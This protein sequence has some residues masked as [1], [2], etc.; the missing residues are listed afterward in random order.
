MSPLINFEV[1][2][3]DSRTPQRKELLQHHAGVLPLGHAPGHHHYC[4]KGVE[5]KF[6]RLLLPLLIPVFLIL[7]LR[8]A[9]IS[10]AGAGTKAP[11]TVKALSCSAADV[12]HALNQA[13]DGDTVSIPAGTCHWTTGIQYVLVG[14]LTMTGA[15]DQSLG[16]GDKTII[17][18]DMNP[19]GDPPL[20]LITTAAGQTFRFTGITLRGGSMKTTYNGAIRITGTSK[21]V[22]VD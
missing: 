22:R 16:G 20:I 1:L 3:T 7:S 9:H 14:S 2:W 8:A 15:G 19:H 6:P 11:K 12:Q 13:N 4:E 18:D 5:M 10:T 17:V 21:A